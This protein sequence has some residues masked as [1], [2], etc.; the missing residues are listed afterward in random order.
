[1]RLR[2]IAHY[3]RRPLRRPTCGM[4]MSIEFEKAIFCVRPRP[5]TAWW[6]P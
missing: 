6:L 3:D 1:V 4:G 2:L 5:P